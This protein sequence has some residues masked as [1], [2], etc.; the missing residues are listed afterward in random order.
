MSNHPT[1]RALKLLS[2]L[3]SHR[4][5][6]GTELAARLEVTERTVRRDVDRLRE[7][8][9][10][11]D[12]TTGKFGGYRL[13]T[14]SHMPP[15]I[16]DDEE[17]VA[18]AV[19]LRYAAA[20][21]IQGFDE[22]SLRALAKI[23][24]LLPHR[25]RRR[26][27]ALHSSVT[28]MRRSG[29]GAVVDSEALS[30]LAA[31]CRDK[32][33]VRFEYRRGDGEISKR[34]VEPHQLVAVGHR[35]YLVAWDQLR[36]DWRTFRLD[37]LNNV[38][39]VGS[40]FTLRAIPG[41]DAEVY[42]ASSLGLMAPQQ[43]ATLAIQATFPELEEVLRWFDHGPIETDVNRCRVRIRSEDIGR[44]TMAVARIALV[45][46]VTV[47]EPAE[48]VDQVNALALN[49]STETR[50]EELSVAQSRHRE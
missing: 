29:D 4:F 41:G 18:V 27:S 2:L 14:G 9:Y 21:A 42:A 34:L 23:E 50:G 13:A 22:T 45:A 39:L 24:S 33:C 10:Q 47:V 36:V 15:L 11:V 37:R 31:G 32:E 38:R 20:A 12:S 26:V 17:A 49:L 19:G 3:Q 35:W 16:L 28:S 40:H 5:W 44:L 46:P 25:L 6:S 30:V 1:G 48:L 43:E 8:G 7:L